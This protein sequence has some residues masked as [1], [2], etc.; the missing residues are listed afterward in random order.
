M[1]VT[2]RRLGMDHTTYTDASGVAATT[3]S[4]ASDQLRLAVAA[5][6]DPV[7]AQTVAMTSIKL[8]VAGSIPNF[9][10]AVGTG[11]Y[12]G[13]KTGSDAIAGG[14]LVFADR[15]S[16]GGRTVT[17]VGVVLRQDPGQPS[18]PILT[19]ASQAAADALVQSVR[20]AIRTETVLP[21]GTPIASLSNA[22][23]VH[24]TAVTGSA[25]SEIGWGGMTEP[26]NVAL[27]HPG[28]S[29]ADGATVAQVSVP[30]GEPAQV[31][32]TAGSAVPAVSFGWKVRHAL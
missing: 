30:S 3:V 25:I 12:V 11:G 1:N 18:T 27:R 7:F 2:A 5:M 15:Q 21:A 22:D 9:N 24:S 29:I 17:I 16:I 32:A 10:H 19:A 6:K 31:T 13:I 28:R 8:P 23:G 14:C 20:S 4:T 26:I